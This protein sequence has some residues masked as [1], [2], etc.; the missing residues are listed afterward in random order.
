MGL[1]AYYDLGEEMESLIGT[2]FP[3]GA[4]SEPI[5]TPRYKA[6]DVHVPLG[7]QSDE[8]ELGICRATRLEN[9]H[10]K[11]EVIESPYRGRVSVAR[12]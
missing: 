10:L 7:G 9:T 11:P 2:S 4:V 6:L 3:Y 5:C 8:Y 12:K 1:T